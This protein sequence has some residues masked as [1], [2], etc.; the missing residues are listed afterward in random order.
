MSLPSESGGIVGGLDM[1]LTATNPQTRIVPAEGPV[2][3]RADLQRQHEMYSAIWRRLLRTL[4]S[5]GGTEEA[6]AAEPTKEF[7]DI[8]GPSDDFVVRAF[9]SMWPYLSPDA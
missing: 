6:L 3:T 9:Q 2:L 5:G 1:I 8:M 4:Y 7:N